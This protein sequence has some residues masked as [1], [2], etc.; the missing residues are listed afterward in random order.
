MKRLMPQTIDITVN[1]T[2]PATS[3]ALDPANGVAAT[4]Y[5]PSG[6][7]VVDSVAM[8]RS[9]LG[10]YGYSY[11]PTGTIELGVYTGMVVATDGSKTAVF[12]FKFS[13]VTLKD[14]EAT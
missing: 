4:I 10:A 3:Q 8:T 11:S 5:A 7:K 1:L 9:A 12:T 13:F 2:D 14:M 6:A